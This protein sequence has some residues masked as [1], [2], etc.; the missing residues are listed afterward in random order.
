MK[1]ITDFLWSIETNVVT[2]RVVISAV[3]LITVLLVRWV[4]MRLVVRAAIKSVD[5]RRRWML[6]IRNACFVALMVSLIVI[7]SAELHTFAISIVAFIV[8]VVLA[9]KEL[10]LCLTGGFLKVSS[11]SFSIGDRIE[12]NQI[13]GDVIDQTLLSTKIL[14]IG[15]GQLT[16]QATGRSIVLPNSVFL[17]CPVINESFTEDFVL[18]TIVVPIKTQDDWEA[19]QQQLLEA[20]NTVCQPFIEEA[21]MHIASLTAREGLDTPSVDP[22]VTV[23]LPE[24]DRINLVVRVPAPA[25]RKGRVEQEILRLFLLSRRDHSTEARANDA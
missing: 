24:P 1:T 2:R 4:L 11:G 16:H 17:T 23:S 25:R 22:R 6:Q 18:H 21:R 19:A 20:A 3:V 9:T 5:L 12:I 14:E 15:P 8:A 10:I 7:W 13:R